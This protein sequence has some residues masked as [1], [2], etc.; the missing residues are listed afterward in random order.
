[1]TSIYITENGAYLRKRGGHVVIGRNNEV[2]LEVPLERVDDVTVVDR[3]QVSS[4][5]VTEL[6]ERN[7]PLS[8]ISSYGN[9]L[10]CVVKHENRI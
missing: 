2:L 4:A 7:V 6:L 5:L 9:R 8:W 3:V 10:Y 1:M